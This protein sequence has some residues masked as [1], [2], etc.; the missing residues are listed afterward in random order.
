M[1][2]RSARYSISDTVPTGKV[3]RTMV[4]AAWDISV[5][6]CTYTEERWHDL[7]AAVESIQ[8][9]SISPREI[10]LVVDHNR[11]LFERAHYIPGVIVIENSET[12]GLSGAR[13][14]GIAVAK[15]AL[16]AFLDDD[17]IAEHDWLIRLSQCFEDHQVLGTGG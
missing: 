12:K 7:V 8:R 16:I 3:I 17:A 5:V 4:D 9:Q 11:Q 15:G 1:A 2:D 6:I 14:S 13:N 10:I